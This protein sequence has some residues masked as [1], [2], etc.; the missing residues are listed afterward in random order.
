MLNPEV[1]WTATYDAADIVMR[2]T[3]T[4]DDALYAQALE[5]ADP[6]MDESDIFTEAMKTFVRVQLAK[7]VAALGGSMPEIEDVPGRGNKTAA[8]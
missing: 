4:V 3:V 7:R 1:V 6:G 5:L 8:P 2:T